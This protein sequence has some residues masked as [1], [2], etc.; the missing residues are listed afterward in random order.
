M[1]LID[2]V[3]VEFELKLVSAH[4]GLA[5]DVNDGSFARFGLEVLAK[6]CSILAGIRHEKTEMS[7]YS[8]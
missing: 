6:V 7:S 2:T 8:V 4:Q 5:D 1:L 3:V